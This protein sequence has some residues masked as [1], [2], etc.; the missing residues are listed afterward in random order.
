M[1]A[2]P[3]RSLTP[4]KGRPTP[5]RDPVASRRFDTATLEWIA[6]GGLVVALIAVAAWFA[7]DQ[8]SRNIHGGGG[9]SSAVTV[10]EPPG[11]A[12]LDA[13]A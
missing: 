2:R 8:E 12:A 10:V 6:V 11:D 3:A 4:P 13:A 5:P 1:T 7:R 9:H